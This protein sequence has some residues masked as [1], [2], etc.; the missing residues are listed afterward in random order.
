MQII[1]FGQKSFGFRDYF[2]GF[3]L[4]AVDYGIMSSP[5]S[6]KAVHNAKFFAASLWG[7]IFSKKKR[8]PHI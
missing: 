7:V 4:S 5:C 3:E 2:S 1:R 6:L 8:M